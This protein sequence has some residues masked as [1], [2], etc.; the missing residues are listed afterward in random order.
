MGESLL[1]GTEIG[2]GQHYHGYMSK[3]GWH[4]VCSGESDSVR[5]RNC[6]G[7]PL[8]ARRLSCEV[9][10]NASCTRRMRIGSARSAFRQ[11]YK[12]LCFRMIARSSGGPSRS[13]GF[14]G[15]TFR[16]SRA[17][18]NLRIACLR[19]L[20]SGACISGGLTCRVSSRIRLTWSEDWR[21]TLRLFEA[22][23]RTDRERLRDVLMAGALHVWGPDF[24]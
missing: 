7:A 6:C 18:A 14:G 1:R 20:Q 4:I 10:T 23:C 16:W 5:S 19:L 11:A 2:G 3:N 24:S 8:L 9:A 17:H 15:W 13:L 21:A 22:T 12:A